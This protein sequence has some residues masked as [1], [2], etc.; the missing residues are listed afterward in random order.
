MGVNTTHAQA[1]PSDPTVDGFDNNAASLSVSSS[2][3]TLYRQAAS[4]A[5]NEAL[6][7]QNQ[8]NPVLICDISSAG[9]VNKAVEAFAA[10]A[11]RKELTESEKT[12]LAALSTNIS[13]PLEG[14]R[15]ALQTVLTSAKFL[16]RVEVGSLGQGKL[17][18]FEVASRLSYF[19]WGSTPDASLL[20]AARDGSLLRPDARRAQAERMLADAKSAAFVDRFAMLWLGLKALDKHTV[21][22]QVYPNFSENLRASMAQEASLFIR[23]F[24]EKPR[25]FN[26]FLTGN[27]AFVNSTLAAH[28]GLT[29]PNS[30]TLVRV[31]LPANSHR[32]GYLHLGAFLT[33]GAAPNYGSPIKRGVWILHN[34]LCDEL[35][36]PPVNTPPIDVPATGAKS[37]RDRLAQHRKDPAC[38]ACHDRI[39]PIGLGLERYDGIGT[40]SGDTI[41]ASGAVFG[42]TFSDSTGLAERI[43]ADAR[44]DAC[45]VR[46]MMAFALGRKPSGPDESVIAE[47][48]RSF[49]ANGKQIR[50]LALDL[51]SHPTF[52]E[53]G[54]L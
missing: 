38:A 20:E 33:V 46:K 14:L 39:D 11:W 5:I 29:D 45:V 49:L 23:E 6:S 43:I 25:N 53:R 47:L 54:G 22:R 28:Y 37:V 26:E 9:C 40:Y 10:R 51:I 7:V 24:F 1:F 50:A 19:L 12:T 30:S 42:A 36:P 8:S 21:D 52:A 13:P 15:T 4:D 32:G 27:F 2:L 34:L 18:A 41:D 17:D 31:T 3:F 35:P 48:G 16:F 44:F